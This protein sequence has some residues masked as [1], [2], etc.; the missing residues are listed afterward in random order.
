MFL[1]LI[2]GHSQE[3][4][5]YAILEILVFPIKGLQFNLFNLPFLIFSL[6]SKI[7]FPNNNPSDLLYPTHCSFRLGS[8]NIA[9]N[10]ITEKVVVFFTL[11]P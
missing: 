4:L 9:N 1:G 10:M 7:M 8:N 5:K 2:I 11:C 6:I 3:I